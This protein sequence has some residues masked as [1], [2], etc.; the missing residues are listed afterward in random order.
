M[1]FTNASGKD[2]LIVAGDGLW[3]VRSSSLGRSNARCK[4]LVDTPAFTNIKDLDVSRVDVNTK[5]ALSIW[6]T[7]SRNAISYL[8]FEDLD[9]T[10]MDTPEPVEVIPEGQGGYFSSFMDERGNQSLVYA[11][12]DRDLVL[13]EQAVETGI[14]N[15]I[16]FIVRTAC[17]SY[18]MVPSYLCTVSITDS[19][20]HLPV[21]N[22][23]VHINSASWVTLSANGM[24]YSITP[25]G[26]QLEADNAGEIAF[27]IPTTDISSTLLTINSIKDP[28]G[29]V[30]ELTGG[31]FR[32][33][34]SHYTL[35]ELG[36]IRT[37]D[38]LKSARTAFGE[39]VFAGSNITD[40]DFDSAASAFKTLQERHMEL[41]TGA[42]QAMRITTLTVEEVTWL[43]WSWFHWIER[44]ATRVVRWVVEC[45]GEW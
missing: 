18:E 5:L 26:I 36:N 28:D 17:Q 12:E 9:I 38:E 29:A 31:P 21:S 35:K 15:N 16:P 25:G 24:T 7:N 34:P 20:L 37:A 3:H 1:T 13:L 27:V 6:V 23:S 40:E 19:K 4:K 45:I 41:T 10:G 11:N 22:A 44:Q 8:K 2:D 32:I 42:G 30:L 14:W 43:P 33:D 39:P